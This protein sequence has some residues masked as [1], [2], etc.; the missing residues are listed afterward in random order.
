MPSDGDKLN[1]LLSGLLDG[2][3]DEHE[4][5]EA[6][7][8]LSASPEARQVFESLQ[9]NQRLLSAA[10]STS[11]STLGPDFTQR[12]LAAVADQR[13]H[14]VQPESTTATAAQHTNTT[15]FNPRR[16]STFTNAAA[17]VAGL[18]ATWLLIINILPDPSATQ[19]APLLGNAD[20]AN[21]AGSGDATNSNAANLNTA[22]SNTAN[23]S[24]AN[25]ST[26]NSSTG[27]SES[28]VPA[29]VRVNG[30]GIGMLT[31]GEPELGSDTATTREVP[32]AGEQGNAPVQ[33]V[34]Q[35]QWK[36]SMAMVLHVSPTKDAYESGLMEAY[37]ADA[38]V[39]TVVPIVAD[40]EVENALQ[41]SEMIVT[42]AAAG[43]SALYFVRADAAVIDALFQRVWA[44]VGNFTKA[45]Y[46]VAIEDPQSRLFE[47]LAQ[48]TGS[49][50]AVS[51]SFAAPVSR[52]N[53]GKPD[54]TMPLFKSQ[55][56]LVA[57][58]RRPDEI[59]SAPMMLPTAY[60]EMS[61]VLILV[62]LP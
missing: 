21:N 26:A 1:E 36:M 18:A 61:N 8:A 39:P 22:N 23:S 10:A 57:K 28:N 12:V 44:D 3:L 2:V 35:L 7:S 38:G 30:S 59:P 55:Q 52:L 42:D 37:M 46:N 50:F 40:A 25:S 56:K 14:H 60:G 16:L 43:S 20:G 11:R 54:T 17:V 49:R 15:S 9:A 19:T 24:T 62:E 53:S 27:D 47:K 5:R 29:N 41:D 58:Q 45:H 48:G 51:E 33:Y 32:A 13:P 31:Q 34:S 6:E 4:R